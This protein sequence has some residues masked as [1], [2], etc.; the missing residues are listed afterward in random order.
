M[1]M[2][3]V[4]MVGG[5]LGWICYRAR[6]QRK[7][8]AAIEAAGGDLIFDWQAGLA[9]FGASLGRASLRKSQRSPFSNLMIL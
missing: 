3:L 1:L 4:L 5:S 8:V 7:A 9:V 2:L 6:V